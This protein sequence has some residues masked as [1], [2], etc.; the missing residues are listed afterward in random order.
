MIQITRIDG[1]PFFINPDLIEVLEA[2]HDTHITLTNGHKYVC[3]E[4]P[5]VIVE[6]IADFRRQSFGAVR[7]A[8]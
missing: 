6:R 5:S 7:R 4:P 1:T 3:S 8:S 2:M